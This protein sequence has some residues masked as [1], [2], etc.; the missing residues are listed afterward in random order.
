MGPHAPR[1]AGGTESMHVG[2]QITVRAKKGKKT[3]DRKGQENW[4]QKFFCPFSKGFQK[5]ARK[6]RPVRNQSETG[7]DE[8]LPMS[9]W[10]RDGGIT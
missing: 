1:T 4:G 10:W 7:G 5:R 2:D 6:P 9:L 3:R 8:T